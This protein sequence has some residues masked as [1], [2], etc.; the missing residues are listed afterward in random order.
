MNDRLEL[1][2]H[3]VNRVYFSVCIRLNDGFRNV[4]RMPVIQLG[5]NVDEVRTDDSSSSPEKVPALSAHRHE[6]QSLLM[7]FANERLR[8]TDNVRIESPTE[9]AVGRNYS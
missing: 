2:V 1:V 8:R 7:V 5:K 6:I 9:A 3:D 4:L